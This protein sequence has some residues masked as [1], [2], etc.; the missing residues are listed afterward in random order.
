M[1]KLRHIAIAA[2]DPDSF[3]RT[4]Q[5]LF[6][7]A[8]VGRHDSDLAKGVFLSDGT[9]SIAVLRFHTDQLG[10][11]MDFAGLHHVG[12]LVDDM[13]ATRTRL[14]AAGMKTVM[15]IPEG[16]DGSFFEAKFM[17]PDGFLFDVAEHPWLGSEPLADAET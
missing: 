9:L 5:D 11:G 13:D 6:D 2:D 16:H 12:F 17:T 8:E 4:L 7:F 15:D 10:K 3:A 1:A 14:K